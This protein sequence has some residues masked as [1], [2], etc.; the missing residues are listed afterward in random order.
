MSDFRIRQRDTA[1]FAQAEQPRELPLELRGEAGEIGGLE[2]L[3]LDLNA[4][5]NRPSV[6]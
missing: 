6:P 4:H 5:E 3:G 2:V 1:T